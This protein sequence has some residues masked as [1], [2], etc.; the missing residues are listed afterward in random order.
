MSPNIQPMTF[1]EWR[2]ANPDIELEMVECENCNGS[3][4][5]ECSC[6]DEHDCGACNGKGKYAKGGFTLKDLYEAQLEKDKKLL[7]TSKLITI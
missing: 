1:A 7:Q 5:H 2:K 3:G 4:F 6:G